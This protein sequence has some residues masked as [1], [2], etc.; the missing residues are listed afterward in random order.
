M[1]SAIVS[2]LVLMN[3]TGV[4]AAE[5]IRADLAALES[6]IENVQSGDFRA[7][8][9]SLSPGAKKKLAQSDHAFRDIVEKLRDKT[10]V[11]VKIG[12]SANIEEL[13]GFKTKVS[14]PKVLASGWIPVYAHQSNGLM[15][16][17]ASL[18]LTCVRGRV[19]APGNFEKCFISDI[20]LK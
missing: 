13:P 19:E 3:F 5:S 14:G 17:V 9:D 2:G 18:H 16:E 12:S 4:M 10:L 8:E 7:F 1:R 20:R 15:T 11:T 6:F